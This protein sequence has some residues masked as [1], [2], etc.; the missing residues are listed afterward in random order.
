MAPLAPVPCPATFIPRKDGWIWEKAESGVGAGG[1]Q[2]LQ[3][4]GMSNL[5]TLSGKPA[6][7][8]GHWSCPDLLG[9]PSDRRLEAISLMWAKVPSACLAHLSIASELRRERPSVIHG[10]QHTSLPLTPASQRGSLHTGLRSW[11]CGG[12]SSNPPPGGMRLRGQAA[13]RGELKGSRV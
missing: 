3:L 4:L 9:G 7:V 12:F 2:A 8:W 11:G 13:S 10:P 5:R 1:V 6:P